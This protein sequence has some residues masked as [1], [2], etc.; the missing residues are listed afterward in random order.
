[1]SLIKTEVVGDWKIAKML[2]T[3]SQTPLYKAFRNVFRFAQIL[4]QSLKK[5]R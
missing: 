1:M 3:G 4:E 5:I 2:L